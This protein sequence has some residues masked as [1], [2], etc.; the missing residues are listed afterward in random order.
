MLAI[1]TIHHVSLCVTD[2]AQARHFYGGVLGLRELARPAFQFE[3]AWYEVGDRQLHLLVKPAAT[4]LRG[5]TTL[6]PGDGHVALRVA[7]YHATVAH[8]HQHGVVCRELPVNVTPWPQIFIA[9]PDGNLIELNAE[10][11]D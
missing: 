4:T 3:G 7:S 2:L 6:D 9:D 8:L 1:E 11:L 10:R 5:V